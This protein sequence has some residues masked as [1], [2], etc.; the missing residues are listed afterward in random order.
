[1]EMYTDPTRIH[2]TD[3]GHVE[4]NPVFAYLDAFDS[5][6][7]KVAELKT[8]YEKGKVGDV[9]LKEYLVKVLNEFLDPIRKRRQEFAKSANLDEILEE[10]KRRVF[11]IAEET[12]AQA[13]KAIGIE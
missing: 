2:P 12:L 5:A 13:R 8:R 11:P 1:M 7:D 10:G 4:G 3:L 9:E 6:K